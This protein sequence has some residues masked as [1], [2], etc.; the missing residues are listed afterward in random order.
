MTMQASFD[1]AFGLCS[2]GIDVADVLT[3]N[4]TG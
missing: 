1:S 3:L 2:L 4:L